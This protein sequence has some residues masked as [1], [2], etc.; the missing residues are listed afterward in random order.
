MT[1]SPPHQGQ[2]RR[3]TAQ[4]RRSRT[5]ETRMLDRNLTRTQTIARLN[6]RARLGLDRTATI[7]VTSTLLAYLSDGTAKSFVLARARTLQAA[8]NCSFNEDSPERDFAAFEIDGIGCFLKVDCYDQDLQY[9]SEDP[10]DASITRR[11]VTIMARED[12]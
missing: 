11:V 1:I 10:A 9:G 12:Y 5:K 6:D 7:V 2:R 3:G 4:G 8:R